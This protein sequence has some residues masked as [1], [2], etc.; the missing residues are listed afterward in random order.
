MELNSEKETSGSQL[1][2]LQQQRY[3]FLFLTYGLAG[4]EIVKN[5]QGKGRKSWLAFLDKMNIVLQAKPST[6]EYYNA[7]YETFQLNEVYTG[8]QIIGSVNETRRE[9]GLQPYV[10]RIKIQSEYDFN[11][12]FLI[13]DIYEEEELIGGETTKVFKG[14]KP[15]DKVK[16]E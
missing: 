2:P 4:V 15:I 3:D 13:E 8:G 14:Y 12:V 16:P 6:K 9:M 1:T 5:V 7:L 10:E 11:M